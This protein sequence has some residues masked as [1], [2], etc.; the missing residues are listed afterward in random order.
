M[1]LAA[2]AV[3]VALALA[4]FAVL[5]SVAAID[6]SVTVEAG[7]EHVIDIDP[8]Y[9][10]AESADE[11]TAE[12]VDDGNP[13]TVVVKG[14]S[15]G[16]TIVT[17]T[18]TQG[19]LP[20]LVY[21]VV[22]LPF[23]FNKIEFVDESDGIVAAGPQVTVRVTLQS[24][25]VAST[26]NLT[27]PTTGLSIQKGDIT[28]QSDT[29]VPN[30]GN[31]EV[32]VKTADFIIN[33]AGAA[34]GYYTLTFTADYNG[35]AFNEPTGVQPVI[36]TLTLVVLP[37][38]INKIEFVDE[39]DGIVAAGPQVTVRVTLQA[40]TI[41]STVNLTIP[42]TGLSI[43][44]GDITTQ[45]DTQVPDDGNTDDVVEKTADFI[46][47]TAGA[48][49]GDYTLTF[50]A[51]YNG[52]AFNE[53]TGR[54]DDIETI[55]LTIGEPGE[56]L[57]SAALA[58]ANV[59][60]GAPSTDTGATPDK[61]TKRAGSTIYLAVT[62]SNSLGAP[63]NPADVNH[64]TVIAPRATVS[65]DKGANS[66]DNSKTFST[67]VG[68]VQ[69][70]AVRSDTP[71]TITVRAFVTG[72]SG[73][74]STDSLDL[75][76]TGPAD[77]ISVG[78]ASTAL[79]T[80]TTA[81]DTGTDDINESNEATVEITAVD[82]SGNDADLAFGAVTVAVVDADEEAAD[83]ITAVAAQGQDDDG[84][85]DPRTVVVT[86]STD[87]A[88]PGEYTFSATLGEDDPVTT[89]IIVAGD[90]AKISLS[91]E[92]AEGS[93]IV[94]VT[95]T[96]TD[97]GGHQVPNIHEVDFVAVGSLA[98]TALDDDDDNDDNGA[99]RA[100]DA[101]AASV[102][103]VIVGAS[104]TATIIASV[105]AGVDDVTMI[106]VGEDADAEPAG[107]S[108][109]DFSGTSGLVSYSGPEATA[110]ALSALLAGRA[111]AIWL[112]NNG[113]WVLYANVDGVM[114]QGSSDFTVTSGDVLYISN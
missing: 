8:A 48:P 80:T 35:P 76:F 68:A 97:E 46:I 65:D 94:T 54:R 26:V 69:V 15:A 41:A 47:N 6:G 27:I 96:V 44:K 71:G 70:F 7:E 81:D 53:P 106:T 58:P 17:I 91:T 104:G 88:A 59:K 36:E 83:G 90:P 105:G 72:P 45:S 77:V 87:D 10:A 32:T 2:L 108:L 51:D 20:D 109:S 67:D 100:T 1:N 103:Y 86:I 37:F 79:P 9:D 64:V 16:T 11:P 38:G 43:Q 33:T 23:G 101:G 49:A 12:I 13:N 18:D 75:S 63:A 5:Q 28:T 82:D 98:I 84:D 4:L 93:S 99:Q 102:R 3:L 21:R 92:Q 40:S 34:A 111:S 19:V 52:P 113:S 60:D 114:V 22:V 55:V 31:T 95:A 30:D 74:Q 50:T 112:S 29:Q 110:S 62:S 57:A 56:G 85:P 66:E 25:I 14:R 73:I 61:T 78:E 107:P 24:L 39:S 89:T 42:T